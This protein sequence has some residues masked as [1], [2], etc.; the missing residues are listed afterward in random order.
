M[1]LTP[2]DSIVRPSVLRSVLQHHHFQLKKSLGQN[3]LIDARILDTILSAVEAGPDDGALE[4]GPGAG[5]LTQALGLR[6]KRVVA[7]EKDRSLEPI[8]NETLT[9]LTNVSV[10]FEDFLEVNLVELWRSFEGCQKVSV[11]ANLPYYVTTPILFRLLESD[12]SVHEIVVMVQKE[13]AD[14]LA[15]NP[16]GKDYGALTVSVQFRA[17]VEKVVRVPPSSF[18][19]PPNVESTVIRLRC[20]PHPTAHVVS[21]QAF[22]TVV[23]AGFGTRRKTLLN[24]LSG[25]MGLTKDTCRAWLNQAGISPERRAE[26]LSIDEFARLANEHSA[27]SSAL[28]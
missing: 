2:G 9:E 10:R 12:V 20:R 21:E 15:A 8:L 16:G 23:R 19:P 18:M 4:I 28:T 5:V 11:V 27:F 25:G 26:T 1:N 7:V 14:R 13:V 22:S 24:A 17:D 3:F 6:C